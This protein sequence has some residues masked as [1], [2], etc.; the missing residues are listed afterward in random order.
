MVGP[1]RL[2]HI[3]SVAVMVGVALGLLAAPG[4][5]STAQL[6]DVVLPPE[7]KYTPPGGVCPPGSATVLVYQAEPGEANRVSVASSAQAFR[8]TDPAAVIHAGRGCTTIDRHRVNCSEPGR[9]ISDV[10]IDGGDGADTIRSRSVIMTVNGGRGND[11]LV[12]GPF[13]DLLY[14]GPGA[15]LLR[16]RDGGDLLYDAAPR[17]PFGSS[18][19]AAFFPPPFFGFTFGSRTVV[20]L[21][22]PGRGRDYFEGGSGRDTISYEGRLGG[23]TLDLADPAAVAGA[24][25]E[26]D[27]VRRVEGALGGAGDDRLLGSS[28][29]DQLDGTRGD[30]RIVA[31]GGADFIEGGTGRNVIV[32]G[33]GD[34]SINALYRPSDYGAE[35][36]FCGAGVD[37]V[38]WSFPSDFVNDDCELLEFNFLREGGLFG[39]DVRSQ[40]PLRKRGA[41]LVL[42]APEL[43]CYFVA[44][45][46]GCGLRLDLLVDGPATRRGTAP[47]QGT[48]LGSQSYTFSPD[49][50]KG[51]S[52]SL[53]R[54]GLRILRRHR[55]LRVRV[56]VTEDAPHQPGGYLTVLRA[57]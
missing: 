10:F 44:N 43:W 40:L 24:R 37:H 48:L 45:P 47:P 2:I 8:I 5:A 57:P 16:G 13:R 46:S 49:E 36:T 9:V 55:A 25:G 41:H 19:L 53:S 14:G 34:D 3:V 50:R 54:A 30:D 23:V 17:L 20:P 27:S 4:S 18:D 52:L 12:G 51:V 32:A 42:V 38:S 26:H 15:D 1:R 29:G 39:G 35:R 56:R 22:N 6:V 28:R 21:A 33:P 31:R 7:C 11:V